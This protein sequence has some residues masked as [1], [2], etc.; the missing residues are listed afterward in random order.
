MLFVLG[1]GSNIA[2]S[3]T[4]TTLFRDIFPKIKNWQAA[5]IVSGI[6]FTTGLAFVTPVKNL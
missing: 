1:I 6:C 4:L 5:V 2:M 3:S